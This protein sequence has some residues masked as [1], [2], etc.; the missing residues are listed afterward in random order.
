MHI[1]DVIPSLIESKYWK[2]K[3][4][5]TFGIKREDMPQVHKDHYDELVQHIRNH[6]GNYIKK[7]ADP[8]TLK[9]V[10]CEFSDEGIEKMIHAKD[11]VAGTTREKPLLVSQDNFIVDGH[12]RWLAA[13][14]LNETIPVLKFSIP[15]KQLFNIIK[16]FDHT[17]YKEIYEVMISPQNQ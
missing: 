6:G 7:H 9:A 8:K 2:P 3:P 14:H 4:E 15:I 1:A 13:Y 11:E 16:D 5:D 17:T 12:H 10:Q